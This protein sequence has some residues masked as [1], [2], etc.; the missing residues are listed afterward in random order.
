V[1]EPVTDDDLDALRREVEDLRDKLATTE[2]DVRQL[3]GPDRPPRVKF[4]SDPQSRAAR[5]WLRSGGAAG[6][7]ERAGW[8]GD[9][10]NG[11]QWAAGHLRVP[12]Y[13]RWYRIRS[14]ARRL[15]V[16]GVLWIVVT[17]VG[18]VAWG[19]GSPWAPDTGCAG[20]TA[21]VAGE[22]VVVRAA[23]LNGRFLHRL[24]GK[25][26]DPRETHAAAERAGRAAVIAVLAAQAAAKGEADPPAVRADTA[27]YQRRQAAVL[28]QKTAACGVPCQPGQAPGQASTTVAF[29]PAGANPVWEA[30]ARAAAVAAGARGQALDIAMRLAWAESQFNPTARNP[31][32]SAAGVWQIMRSVHSDDPD[33]GRWADP[34]AS[35]RMMRRISKDFTDW[36]PWSTWP[37]V[38]REL[39]TTGAG[40]T[41]ANA[42]STAPAA[43]SAPSSYRTGAG[44]AWGGYSNGRIPV[45][46]LAHPASAPRALL[47]P[48]AAVELDRLSAA[49]AAR[50]G[51]PLGITDSYRDLAGQVDV[52][53]RK[54]GLAAKPGTS[55]HG[56]ALAV[57]VVVGGYGATDYLWL[58]ENAPRF[59][60]DNPDWARP[61]GSSR[62]EPWHWEFQ[63]TGGT[64]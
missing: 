11:A 53:R 20:N 2:Y 8:G 61:G 34:Y 23:K 6:W 5:G 38:Q 24:A 37:A 57:D 31:S 45:S 63:P 21:A 58:R 19:P 14:R 48:D 43:C 49:Y 18:A 36:S 9:K 62:H 64:A 60:W 7:A 32:S 30:R 55:N 47:R 35:A 3:R 13:G 50:F 41:T 25:P 51:H 12:G 40:V 10:P 52:A 27:A 22:S 16:W 46:A 56:W 39:A 15:A 4:P 28:T 33:I 1:S 17:G 44:A 29:R 59:G 42:S 26:P 54:P